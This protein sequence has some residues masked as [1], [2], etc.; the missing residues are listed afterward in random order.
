MS[1]N[2][3]TTRLLDDLDK[4]AMMGGEIS[5]EALEAHTEVWKGSGMPNYTHGK[6]VSLEWEKR[7]F[8][9]KAKADE[10]KRPVYQKPFIEYTQVD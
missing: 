8:K 3:I 10:T 1:P 9:N 7:S 6:T 5:I 2:L 4:E